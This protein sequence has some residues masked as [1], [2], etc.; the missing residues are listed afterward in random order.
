LKY[1]LTILLFISCAAEAQTWTVG[2]NVGANGGYPVKP[3]HFI[4]LSNYAG[5]QNNKPWKMYDA[6]GYTNPAYG[7]LQFT[8]NA[9]GAKGDTT[10]FM[11]ENF[12]P[13]FY[14]NGSAKAT[15]YAGNRGCRVIYDWSGDKDMF[16]TSH[17]TTIKAMYGAENSFDAGDTLYFYNIDFL[18]SLAADQR[19]K[20]LA[21]PDSLLTPVAK[22]ATKGQLHQ[23]T[24]ITTNFTCRYMLVRAVLKDH[25]GYQ[26][27]ESFQEIA[28]YGTRPSD[29]AAGTKRPTAANYT[30]PLPKKPVFSQFDGTDLIQGIRPDT[31]R[32]NGTVRIYAG[33]NYWASTVSGG[34]SASTETYAFD[35]FADVGP[36]Q[37]PQFKAAGQKFWWSI[38]GVSA[39]FAANY[40][41][42]YEQPVDIDHQTD[43]G[44]YGLNFTREARFYFHYAAKFGAVAVSSALTPG[45]TGDGSYPNGQNTISA[46]EPNNE[47]EFKGI[48]P[49]MVV[50]H[51]NAVYDGYES[52]YGAHT[53]IKNADPNFQ[54]IMPA[55]VERDT[56]YHEALIWLSRFTRTDKKV[57]FDWINFHHY[58]CDLNDVPGS[59][60]YQQQLGTSGRSPEK[61]RLYSENL[62]Y[63]K[64]L[65]NLLDGDTTKKT[66]NSET[67]YDNI[68]TA[69][70]TPVGNPGWVSNYSYH[71]L[72]GVTIPT[73]TALQSK[74]IVMSR[75]ETI[76]AASGLTAQQEFAFSNSDLSTVINNT[77]YGS[78]GITG[79]YNGGTFV[80]TVF[81]PWWYYHAGK[82]TI[83]KDY[84]PDSVYTGFGDTALN[85]CRWKSDIHTDSVIYEIWKGTTTN[86]TLTGQ[87]LTIPG[88]N[89]STIAVF[90]SSMV[91]TAPIV[92]SAT[93][94]SGVL[95]YT[96]TEE[97]KYYRANVTSGG[98]SPPSCVTNISPANGTTVAGQTSSA[99]AWNSDGTAT[100]YDL[101]FDGVFLLNQSGTTYTKTGLTANTTHTFYAIPRNA[102][103]AAT[104]CSGNSTSFTTAA[105]V[106]GCTT[107]IL[108]TPG[109]T[110]ATTTT[111]ALSWNA[112]SG[113]TS[114]D[115][116]GPYIGGT[117]P[118][119]PSYTGI[120]ALR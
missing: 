8:V 17:R 105:P 114:Y 12:F 15:T 9:Q 30:G 41:S 71:N 99:L 56:C 70:H 106:P 5:R 26:T 11:P 81:Y 27:T 69:Q 57:I 13:E 50:N 2:T 96:A 89:N 79:G 76:Q 21:R 93:A 36:T 73:Y 103:G 116:F 97:P 49:M 100:S 64:F 28:F 90:R 46:V 75:L 59:A 113:A 29:S 20:Y 92:S 25:G 34:G 112:A 23:W 78:P 24:S 82:H 38:R 48:T 52:R 37:Y 65:Y 6:F 7:N 77:I 1:L 94:S 68:D 55:S 14:I 95:S 10:A 84:Y 108:P 72:A 35:H 111:A 16:D 110:V 101:Y 102:S 88:L 51:V 45:W 63:T 4:D 86:T 87:T 53:G 104:G 33:K 31:L 44:E 109:S 32:Y 61:D 91:S 115:V 119:S 18:F 117:P 43:E 19:A 3:A 40:S 118:G 85:I 107:N 66:T 80:P 22:L 83:L 42:A 60:T 67:G 58:P 74:A 62:L 54:L 39:W 120:T 47:Y 98:G